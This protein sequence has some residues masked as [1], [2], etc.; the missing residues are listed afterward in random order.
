MR[1]TILRAG[2]LVA[3]G[4][5]LTIAT[6][7]AHAAQPASTDQG[8]AV[9]ATRA[10]PS[11]S[12]GDARA[13]EE[14]ERLVTQL[15]SPDASARAAATRTLGQLGPDAIPAIARKLADLRKL[16]TAPIVAALKQAKDA[17]GK[18]ASTDQRDL[19]L[20]LPP[21]DA[22]Q[23]PA[24]T[25][26]ALVHGLAHAGGL[27]GARELV[28]AAGDHGGAFRPE[29]ARLLRDLADPAVPALIEARRN[30]SPD[31]QK[32]A[33]AQLEAMGKRIP[34]DAVQAKDN[35]VL[36]A[37]LRAYA[38]IHDMDA[39]PVILSFVNADRVQV[40]TA[41]REAVVSFGQDALWKLREAYANVAGKP[42][43]DAWTAADVAR[44]LF[45]AYDRLRLQEVYE[46]LEQG[47]ALEHGGDTAGAAAAFDKVLARQ[48]L[49][50][51]RAEM[52]PTYLALG[53]S[54]EDTDAPRALATLRKAARL[55]PDSGRAGQIQAEIAYLEGKELLGRGLADPEP[56]RRALTLD[57]AHDKARLELTRIETA[58]AERS[59]R[60]R[61]AAGVAALVLAAIIGVVLFALRRPAPRTAPRS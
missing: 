39:V 51:R 19:L 6:E 59:D 23:K 4:V 24:L 11:G 27:A 30:A 42:A 31:V 29:L 45:A 40:R 56:F 17:A 5:T 28:K 13:T 58:S 22:G 44:E 34:S 43:P 41:A 25:T 14:L 47:L 12:A 9:P 53:Q 49:L 21:D 61:T 1:K 55:A 3:L 48:P 38:A 18:S 26:V 35:E 54:L 2:N 57:P 60:V 8:R 46:L 52:A 20:R 7:R 15:G 33:L 50:D 16:P 32:W 36:V 10:A 37:V